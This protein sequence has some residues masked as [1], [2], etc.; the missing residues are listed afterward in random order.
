MYTGT[1]L[2]LGGAGLVGLQVCR[3][4]TR[5]FK[6]GRIVVASLTADE[7]HA[8]VAQLAEEF[9]ETE[10]VPA[11]GNLFVP[12]NLAELSRRQLLSDKETRKALRDAL[13]SDFQE[14]YQNNHLVHLILKHRIRLQR[15]RK[16][17]TYFKMR[18]CT[19]QTDRHRDTRSTHSRL[20]SYV[21]FLV[22]FC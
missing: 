11:W 18:D 17:T 13:Y 5:E 22:L 12:H 10:F 1:V 14:A 16:D 20:H 15:N 9:S 19:I 21:F 2:V 7:S 8:A 4:I 6:P 3:H